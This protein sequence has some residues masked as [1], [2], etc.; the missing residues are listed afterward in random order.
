MEGVS[1]K[2]LEATVLGAPSTAV[3]PAGTPDSVRLTLP[4]IPIGFDTVI[5]LATLV[6]PTSTVR[7]EAEDVRVKLGVGTIRV[8]TA[9]WVSVGAVPVTVTK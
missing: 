7:L 8:I 5:V 3:T 1:V 9:L 2:L 4:L 6:P